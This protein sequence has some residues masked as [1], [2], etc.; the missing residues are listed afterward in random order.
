MKTAALLDL[1]VSDLAHIGVVPG[2]TV[3]CLE[4]IVKLDYGPIARSRII[5][6]YNRTVSIIVDL[7]H[8]DRSDMLIL[9]DC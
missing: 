5:Q 4:L 1:I 2:L 6:W 7:A 3:I 9:F 8:A